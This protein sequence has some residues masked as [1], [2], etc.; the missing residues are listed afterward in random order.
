MQARITIKKVSTDD[1]RELIVANL[2]SIGV[3]EPWVY[4][5][6]DESSFF[7]YLARCDGERCEG[8]VA[9]EWQTGRI[10]GVVNLNEIVR[11][12]FQNAYLGYYGMGETQG[13]GLMSEAVGI[14]LTHAFTRLGLH[15]VEANIQPENVRS[16]A[17]AKRLGFRH[18]GR[19]RN[20]LQI[21]GLWR[22][23]DR[24][25]ILC[26]EWNEWESAVQDL[27]V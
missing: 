11:G 24:F 16:I 22:D 5:C 2:S 13:R 15:R 25:A 20:Y 8:F 7:A 26:D 17:L 6:R 10:I 21:G 14:A 27:V 18:E 1:C 12:A 19:S 3:H 23:H 4:P 9:R